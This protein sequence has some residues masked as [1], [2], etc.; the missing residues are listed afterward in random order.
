M[1]Y[2]RESRPLRIITVKGNAIPALLRL[3]EEAESRRKININTAGQE[4]IKSIPGIG[5]ALAERIKKYRDINGKILDEHD[6][7][8]IKGIGEKKL[9]DIIK[10]LEF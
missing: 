4:E 3:K 9:D 8:K 7:L 1:L 10:Y 6:L 5:E 2:V